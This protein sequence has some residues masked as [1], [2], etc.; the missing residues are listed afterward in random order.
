V[1]CPKIARPLAVLL[2]TA[3]ALCAQEYSFR[4][5][6]NADGLANLAVRQIYQDR[7]GFVWVSTENGIFRYDGGS[8]RGLW[9]CTGDSDH[10]GCCIWRSSGRFSPRRWKLWTLPPAG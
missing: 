2:L 8:F 4:T 9:P 1:G 10:L 3:G 5:F 6:G 7:E